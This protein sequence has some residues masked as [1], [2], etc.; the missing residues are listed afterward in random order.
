MKLS[1]AATGVTSVLLHGVALLLV[2]S[3]WSGSASREAEQAGSE[4]ISVAVLGAEERRLPT[5]GRG[6]RS[7]VRGE[8]PTHVAATKGGGEREPRPDQRRRGRGGSDTASER[9]LNLADSADGLTLDREIP[10]RLDRSQLQRLKTDST[11]RSREDRRATP[12]PMKLWLLATG[13]GTLAERRPEALRDPANGIAT[14]LPPSAR[15]GRLGE[16]ARLGDAAM[17]RE[18]GSR[19]GG[20]RSNAGAGVATSPVQGL[21]SRGARIALARPWVKRARASVPAPR[22]GSPAD[23]VD[24]TQEVAS[25]V[26][27]LVHASTAGGP[28]GP[29]PGGQAGPGAPGSGGHEGPGS[30]SAS[31]GHSAGSATDMS[32]DPRLLTYFRQLMARVD[33]LWAKAFPDW[34]IAQGRGGLSV[35]GILVRADG[36]LANAWIVRP[37]GIEEFDRNLIVAVRRAAPFGPIPRSLG[38]RSLTLHITFDAL[39]PAVG[40]A[41]R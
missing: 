14:W 40:R 19:Q 27:S 29:G 24:S 32:R 22:K 34:A 15:G 7:Q 36:G 6:P 28:K 38:R 41:G 26:Q 1:L 8:Q 13:A 25:L 16:P 2:A 17:L 18:G 21:R 5:S 20:E 37:S 3:W 11:R 39:N 31:A 12:N 10:N 30:V 35:V 33:P 9:A 23:T 4:L